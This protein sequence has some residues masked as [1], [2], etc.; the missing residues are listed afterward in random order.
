MVRRQDGTFRDRAS[1]ALALPS[2]V[3]TVI[4]ADFDND[5]WE[6]LFFNNIDEPN[7]VFG[8]PPG[9]A[10]AGDWRVRDAGPLA[11]PFGRGTGAAVADIDGDGVL[12]LLVSHGESEA[13]PLSLFKC[14]RAAG[15]GWLR[16]IPTTRFG[17]PARGA[18]VRLTAGGRTHVRVV[19][20]GS[21]Y[22][23]QM[24]PVAHFGLGRVERADELTI[25]WP[26][27]TRLTLAD[28]PV[29][30]VVEVAYPDG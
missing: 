24:E 25:T 7:R 5:G 17:A 13:Q 11:E 28:P 21:G 8:R 16:V 29:N 2:T 26:D 9:T 15:N 10:D 19:C 23:C 6:E 22:L 4:A 12:E 30:A 20:G 27:G 18:E 1:P 3:R 14:E